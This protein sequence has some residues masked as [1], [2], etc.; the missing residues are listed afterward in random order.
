MEPLR[1]EMRCLALVGI[2]DR[3]WRKVYGRAV[4][5]FC[6]WLSE[7]EGCCLEMKTLD[8]KLRQTL[9]NRYR[10]YLISMGVS[11]FSISTY[12]IPVI[13][14]LQIITDEQADLPGGV[15]NHR[16]TRRSIKSRR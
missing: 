2:T 7:Q 15:R 4:D 3:D 14:A 8:D 6:L 12:L 1:H 11:S 10:A 9:V 13:K 16:G 5:R